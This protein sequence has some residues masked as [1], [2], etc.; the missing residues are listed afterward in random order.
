MEQFAFIL[1]DEIFSH[2]PEGCQVARLALN[3]LNNDEAEDR[4]K[5]M[6]F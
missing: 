5:P 3:Q 2:L 1:E 6:Y 4:A